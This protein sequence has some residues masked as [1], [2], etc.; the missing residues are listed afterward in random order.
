MS[1]P[2][3][4]APPGHELGSPAPGAATAGAQSV[5]TGVVKRPGPAPAED[6][7]SGGGGTSLEYLPHQRIAAVLDEV[8]A[9]KAKV[10]RQ[11]ARFAADTAALRM[12]L[13]AARALYSAPL[14]VPPADDAAEHVCPDGSLRSVMHMDPATRAAFETQGRALADSLGAGD[15]SSALTHIQARA[16]LG[17][18]VLRGVLRTVPDDQTREAVAARPGA[19]FA[20]SPA[21]GTKPAPEELQLWEEANSALARERAANAATRD[22]IVRLRHQLAAGDT[23]L[24]VAIEDNAALRR[25]VADAKAE[26]DAVKAELDAQLAAQARALAEQERER[27]RAL[28]ELDELRTLSARVSD[29]YPRLLR[30]QNELLAAEQAKIDELRAAIKAQRAEQA[31]IPLETQR[32]LQANASKLA[33]LQQARAT[34]EQELAT[35]SASQAEGADHAA[36]ASALDSRIAHERARIEQLKDAMRAEARQPAAIAPSTLAP[37]PVHNRDLTHDPVFSRMDALRTS[38]FSSRGLPP[39]VSAPRAT[40]RRVFGPSSDTTL[41]NIGLDLA[42]LRPALETSFARYGPPPPRAPTA[43]I[44]L[45]SLY[46]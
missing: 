15:E 19:A 17:S 39:P 4:V 42:S 46:P 18:S 45:R 35:A 10:A 23:E 36:Q 27:S 28:A 14:P 1:I 30:E 25:E 22:T 29:H 38:S 41:S 20:A 33:S 7:S 12:D 6:T 5:T 43:G 21:R 26:L 44:G 11:D 37:A 31:G 40:S 34:L 2:R 16:P 8:A 9:M 24:R 3:A 13:N 32:E